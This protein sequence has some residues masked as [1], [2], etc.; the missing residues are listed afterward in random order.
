MAEPD[1]LAPVEFDPALEVEAIGCAPGASG[2]AVED[3]PAPGL[4]ELGDPGL[5]PVGLPFVEEIGPPLGPV[6]PELV[7]SALGPAPVA[8]PEP[9]P[10]P[11]AGIGEP[12]G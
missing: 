9:E 3:P 12:S 5:V 11:G 2:V 4:P 10:I 7:P 1:P 6:A 8:S